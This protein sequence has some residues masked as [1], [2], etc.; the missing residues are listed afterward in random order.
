M[1]L[2]KLR[3]DIQKLKNSIEQNRLNS[4]EAIKVFIYYP[5]EQPPYWKPEEPS[6][7]K[8]ANLFGHA[9]ILKVVDCSKIE[10][11]ALLN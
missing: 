3:S 6:E 9:V 5:E 8:K 2:Q 7:W 4:S 10:N 1:S 11:R